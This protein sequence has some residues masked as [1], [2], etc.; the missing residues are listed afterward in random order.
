MNLSFKKKDETVMYS[1][2]VFSVL[3]GLLVF[4]FYKRK[5]RNRQSPTNK[6]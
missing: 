5:K 2:I 1:I 4:Y 3:T 6:I